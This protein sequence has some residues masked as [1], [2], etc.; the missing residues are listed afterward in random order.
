[1]ERSSRRATSL[2]A[3][4]AAEARSFQLARLIAG[5]SSSAMAN[6]GPGVTSA[7]PSPRARSFCSLIAWRTAGMP[8]RSSC[9]AT[10]SC[11]GR[12]AANA[13]LR[14][15]VDGCGRPEPSRP[16]V[17]LPP[18]RLPGRAGRSRCRSLDGAPARPRPSPRGE[19]DPPTAGSLRPRPLVGRREP[20]GRSRPGRSR[21]GRSRSPSRRR[22]LDLEARTTD[23]SGPDWGV[24]RISI[25]STGLVLSLALA[26]VGSRAMT[27]MPSN[28]DSTS[29]RTTVPTAVPSGTRSSATV[30]RGCLAPAARHVHVPS[31]LLLVNSI[32]ILCDIPADTLLPWR[33]S[34]KRWV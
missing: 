26:L 10:G 27:L 1:M 18:S 19:G 6:R 9:S 15:A 33:G 14:K 17:R 23:T 16:P 7:R 12:R 3:V 22:P 25:R 32:S 20:S 30:P 24:P 13:A 5:N 2:P 31:P 29:A 11:S 4:R 28:V 34:T 8:P 21:S